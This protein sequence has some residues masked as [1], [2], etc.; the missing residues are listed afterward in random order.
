[1]FI[2]PIQDRVDWRRPP[3]LTLALVVLNS[4]I[5]FWSVSYDAE[6]YAALEQL[7]TTKLTAYERTPYLDWLAEEDPGRWLEVRSRSAAG[8][9]SALQSAWM[10]RS[11]DQ[12][13]HTLWQD[14]P[15]DAVWREA[16]AQL[17]QRRDAISWIRWGFTP[18]LPEFSDA[19]IS[20][21]LHGDPWHLF[22][23]MLFLLLFAIPLERHWGASRLLGLYLLSGL[24]GDVLHWLAA[25][26]SYIPSVG[27]SGAIAGLMGIYVGTYGVRRI[28]F[29]Y[30]VGFLF[31]SFRAP[32]IMVFPV[33]L[34]YELMQNA[35]SDSNVNYLAH[36]GGMTGGLLSV[37]ALRG[38]SPREAF[39][40][41]EDLPQQV[42]RK[43]DAVPAY[44]R[45]LNEAL[46]FDQVMKESQLLLA[47]QSDNRALWHFYFDAARKCGTAALDQAM[48]EALSLLNN[49]K[50]KDALVS[51][52]LEDY[53]SGAGDTTRLPPPFQLLEAELYFRRRD[54]HLA[55]Q[56]VMALEKI[57][58]HA[59]LKTLQER[60]F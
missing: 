46:A 15:P 27:A 44:L 31:G 56:R 38:L 5:Y 34:L 60:L 1:M 58:S 47:D 21:F 6:R 55:R 51:A 17:E 50:P 25:M 28:E 22:G 9:E 48:R 36:A 30:T 7:D 39:D 12:R 26:D 42:E 37:L 14:V 59:R 43:A 8:Q 41:V 18:A 23:N 40:V 35:L 20:M 13:I 10:D 3:L 52:L 49:P 57:W 33:W 24:C 54:L 29:F 53:H 11:F 45:R 32:A 19:L 16:R 4:I 2:I